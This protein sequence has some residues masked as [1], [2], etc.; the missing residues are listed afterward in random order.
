MKTLKTISSIL[1]LVCSIFLFASWQYRFLCLLLVVIINRRT[2]KQSSVFRNFKYGYT[3][4]VAVLLVG[5]FCCMP[6]YFQRGRTQLHYLNQS[7][8]RTHTP[9]LV[10]L[11]NAIM[12]EKEA[13]N[14]C[15]KGNAL[16]SNSLMNKMGVHLGGKLLNDAKYDFWHGKTL[17]F[18]TAYYHIGGNPGSF[19]YG[20]IANM[21]IGTDYDAV[22]I[23]RPKHYDKNKEYPVIFFC[24]GY[25]GSWELYQGILSQLDEYIIVS[26]GTRGL[27]GLSFKIDNIFNRYIPY[28]QK[29]G[30]NIDTRQVHIMGLSNGGQAANSAL[31]NYDK[32]FKTIT[33]ISTPC[34]VIKSSAAKVLMIG[35]GKDGSS[36]GLKNAEKKLNSLGTQTALYF[37]KQAN[38]YILAYKQKDIIKFLKENLKD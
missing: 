20:Q 30:Y 16:V 23:T 24:H 33:F 25:M 22:Y 29:L 36:T 17:G 31:K 6:N 35:G 3:I 9:V 7:G 21:L 12:P 2:I 11:A 1:L 38:H 18:Y 37:D 28:I 34:Y 26:I 5:I 15:V 14:L 4:L 13:M 32:K 19:V 10:Y 8:E 27:D